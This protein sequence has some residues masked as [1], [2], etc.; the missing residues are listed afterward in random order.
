MA[1]YKTV[2]VN[3]L[4]KNNP[5]FVQ[6]LGICSTLAVTNLVVNTI[7]MCLALVFT[8]TLSNFAI[9]ALRNKIPSKVRMMAEVL[10]ISFFVIVADMLIK[11]FSPSYRG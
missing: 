8:L 3:N 10:I 9:S 2:F 4:G 7:V 1:N 11:A 5:V 6:I